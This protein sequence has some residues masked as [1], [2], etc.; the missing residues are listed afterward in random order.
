MKK[1]KD[2]GVYH[3]VLVFTKIKKGCVSAISIEDLV[4]AD[5]PKEAMDIS[6]CGKSEDI[7][8]LV[9]RGYSLSHTSS[10]KIRSRDI[11]ELWDCSGSDEPIF[12]KYADFE[13]K[14]KNTTSEITPQNE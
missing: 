9:I 2:V 13:L 3:V 7:S 5:T 11:A 14:D 4:I 1:I 12:E 6:G 10:F 8:K